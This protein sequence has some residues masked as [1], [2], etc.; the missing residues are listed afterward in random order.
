MSKRQNER[1]IA[2]ISI[3]ASFLIP[4]IQ[5]RQSE[6]PTK[7]VAVEAKVMGQKIRHKVAPVYPKEA[8]ISG[9]EGTVKLHAVIATDGSVR[10]LQVESGEP[11][12]AQSATDAV[13]Q[14][15]YE[16]LVMNG[17]PVEVETTIY[18]IFRLNNQSKP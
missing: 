11:H 1:F 8:R 17:K 6:S 12:L 2:V 13:R 15:T 18:V 7:P 14:W 16:P 9:T 4:A 5:A 10:Q 3:S